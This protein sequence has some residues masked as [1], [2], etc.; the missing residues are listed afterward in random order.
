M[1]VQI[2]PPAARQRLQ[3]TVVPLAHVEQ[4]INKTLASWPQVPELGWR[5]CVPKDAGRRLK[6]HVDGQTVY[7]LLEHIAHAK[8]R[9]QENLTQYLDG[10]LPIHIRR[11]KYELDKVKVLQYARRFAAT[12]VLLK[13]IVEKEVE[14][15]NGWLNQGEA[16]VNFAQSNLTPAGLRTQAEET[17]ALVWQQVQADL[18]MQKSQNAQSLQCLI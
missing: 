18:T 17:V 8:R 3:D 6:D 5:N 15:A 7:D 4:A 9:V 13:S 10:K 1:P 12:A 14:L 16:I 11:V 2:F